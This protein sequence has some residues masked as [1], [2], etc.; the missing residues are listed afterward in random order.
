M[1][2]CCVLLAQDESIPVASCC[3]DTHLARQLPLHMQSS[4]QKSRAESTAGRADG[5]LRSSEE[6]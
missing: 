3:I 1:N 6:P 2:S 5:R 4:R